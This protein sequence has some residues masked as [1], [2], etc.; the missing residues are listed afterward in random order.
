[1][2]LE[3]LPILKP[4]MLLLLAFF[5]P[6]FGNTG[7]NLEFLRATSPYCQTCLWGDVE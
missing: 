3:L 7:L 6:V 1:M 4:V 2:D 5:V